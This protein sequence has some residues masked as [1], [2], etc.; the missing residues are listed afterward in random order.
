MLRM[1][2]F[3]IVAACTIVQEARQIEA[4][5]PVRVWLD[6][7]IG[8]SIDDA[9]ALALTLAEPRL[10]LV[11]VSTATRAAEDRAWMA[12]R[13]ITQSGEQPCPIGW[14]RDPQ[15]ASE[16]DWQI[17]YRRHPAVIFNRTLKPS[18][19]SAVE[20]LAEQLTATNQ[21]L[22][23]VAVGPLTNIARLLKEHPKAKANI[24]QIVMMGG[25]LRVGYNGRP[26]VVAEWNIESDLP[27]AQQ[28]FSSGI[29]IKVVPLDVTHDLKL[30]AE[31][32]QAIGAAC[33]RLTFQ[34]QALSQL[35]DEP[36]APLFDAVA[37]AAAAGEAFLRTERVALEIN[38]EGI[39]RIVKNGT[40]VELVTKV[41]SG[42]FFTWCRDTLTAHGPPSLPE[43]PENL[44]HFVPTGKF[45]TRV[46]AWEDFQTDIEKRW[47]MSG[48]VVA[49]NTPPG[50]DNRACQGVI[51][52]DFDD[53]MGQTKTVYTGVVFNPV[54]G[55][56]MGPRTRL[57]FRYWVKGTDRLR[58]Q[59][60]SL[61]NGYHRYL[62]LKNV[63][64]A[65]WQTATVDMTEMRRPD[66]SG[67]P[68]AENERIDD[69]QFYVDPRAELVIDDIVLYEAAAE[70]ET[71]SFPRSILYTGV[72]DTGKQGQ[73]WPGDFDIVPHALP[74]RWK[75]AQ[76]VKH[77]SEARPWLRL[78]LRGLRKVPASTSVAFRYRLTG[79]KSFDVA[80]VNS[81][82]KQRVAV[83]V[84]TTNNGE[85]S[86][87]SVDFA[88]KLKSTPLSTADELQFLLPSGVLQLDDVLLYEPGS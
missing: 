58:V 44:S 34:L 13:M 31:T 27:A 52:Q 83:S 23:I 46:H 67:G 61:S 72:F 53:L 48:R 84:A 30:P 79:A 35:C 25:A 33:N 1:A 66:G 26:P 14:G 63:P 40:P 85:W 42:G 74:A 49:N 60:Y 87:L 57:A 32:S 18:S 29:P 16:I 73:E 43:P 59:L 62:S 36:Q 64:Q 70:G 86:T 47:W 50:R 65:E 68:L 82:T 22:T 76:S 56:P 3:L 69:I 37:V 81:Q 19:K 9:Y 15:P 17:Q 78:H 45:P 7:D 88:D 21:P 11:G 39:T 55:P 2:I 54:P 6:T 4:Q 28:V 77:P 38:D 24:Q 51:T 75:F 10:Q 41:D 5:Q 71:R 8:T 80:L 20:L 12:C